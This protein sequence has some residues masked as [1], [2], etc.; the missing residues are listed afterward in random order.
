MKRGAKKQMR[1][2]EE[3]RSDDDGSDA[4]SARTQRHVCG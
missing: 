3:D 4:V 1:K 2:G